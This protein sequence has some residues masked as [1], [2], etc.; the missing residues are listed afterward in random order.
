LQA[1]LWN[2]PKYAFKAILR[3]ISERFG[4]FGYQRSPKMA[5]KLSQGLR[6]AHSDI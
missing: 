4:N 5:L 1:N 6:M 2:I 3:P